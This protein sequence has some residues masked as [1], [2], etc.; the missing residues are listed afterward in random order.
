[1]GDKSPKAK[2][3]DQQQKVAAKVKGA[4]ATRSKQDAFGHAA[5]P[6]LKGRK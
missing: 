5:T 1:M 6:M 4:A 2:Q 3:R